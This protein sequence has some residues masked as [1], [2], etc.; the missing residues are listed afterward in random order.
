MG[1]NEE[2][3]EEEDKDECLCATLLKVR[4]ISE[5]FGQWFRRVQITAD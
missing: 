3:D 5:M 2:E 1:E 4:G